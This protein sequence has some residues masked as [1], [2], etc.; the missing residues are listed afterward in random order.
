MNLIEYT[1][2]V[3]KNKRAHQQALKAVEDIEEIAAAIFN[4]TEK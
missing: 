2:S 4:F 3:K 1:E